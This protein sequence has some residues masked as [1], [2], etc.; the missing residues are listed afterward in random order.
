MTDMLTALEH[1]QMSLMCQQPV[2]KQRNQMKADLRYILNIMVIILP[3]ISLWRDNSTQ[4]MEN[5]RSF[6]LSL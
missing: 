5:N 6:K 1:D 4:I 3:I 2:A